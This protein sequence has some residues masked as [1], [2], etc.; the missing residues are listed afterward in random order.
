MPIGYTMVDAGILNDDGTSLTQGAKLKF[1]NDVKDILQFG[2]AGTSATKLF[3]CGPDISAYPFAGNLK[4]EDESRFPDFHKNILGT[5]REIAEKMNV[6]S[7]F[8]LLPICC[9][10]SL[11]LKLGIDIKI[12][13]FPDGFIQFM[14]PNLPALALKLNIMPP[15]KLAL[16]FSSLL[17]LPPKL[18][19]LNLT[20]PKLPDFKALF[21]FKMSFITKM[22][23]FMLS[24]VAKIPELALKLPDLPGLFNLICGLAFDAKLFGSIGQDALVLIA[25]T[26]VLI[27]RVVEMSFIDAVGITLGSSPGGITGGLGKFLGYQPPNQSG[28]GSSGSSR[29]KISEYASACVGMS[30]GTSDASKDDDYVR[31]LFVVESQDPNAQGTPDQR[32][33]GYNATKTK[34]SS[35]SS[36]GVFAK[37]CLMAGGA[38]CTL[39]YAGNKDVIRVKTTDSSV[40]LYHDF[41]QDAY[42][43]SAIAGIIQAAIIK[44]AFIKNRGERIID[45]L[46]HVKKGDIIIVRHPDRIGTEHAMIVNDDYI[47]K[48]NLSTIEGG[49]IDDKNG[50]KPT[51]IHKKSYK[52]INSVSVDRSISQGVSPFVMYAEPGT[53]DV[54][55]GGR[56]VY[57]IID[58]EKICT[59]DKGSSVSNL[60][61]DIDPTIAYDNND[62]TK[63]EQFLPRPV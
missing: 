36:S 11:A 48:F 7:N 59:N 15:P 33:I 62:D 42:R 47:E 20:L 54:V 17:S 14:F 28:Q 61:G 52:P 58:G 63:S 6:K 5:Y 40:V 38:S 44:D 1:I 60:A 49:Q 31:R 12:P 37:A 24:L 27:R 41:F 25:A 39:S 55:I 18:P 34:Y 45:D 19:D 4:L 2:S 9:P 13:K 22:P 10:I 3:P 51:A 8:S 23:S 32:A 26:Q 50:N 53:G 57:C 35:T 29:T 16:K 30:I 21:D 56:K 43:S 46:P